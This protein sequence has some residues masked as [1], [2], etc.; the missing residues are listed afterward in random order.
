MPR[1]GSI[2]QSTFNKHHKFDKFPVP[3]NLKRDEQNIFDVETLKATPHG[4]K[5]EKRFQ[6]PKQKGTRHEMKGI[7]TLTLG[8]PLCDPSRAP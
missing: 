4:Q 2:G 7:A 6:H 3:I 8:L 5:Q 1:E